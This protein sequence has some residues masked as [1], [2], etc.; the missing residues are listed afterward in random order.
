M[1][2]MIKN[3][4]KTRKSEKKVQNDENINRLNGLIKLSEGKLH[5]RIFND[6]EIEKFY[7]Q[8]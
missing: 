1:K 7:D 5:L 2:S 3:M 4:R 8:H 6:G